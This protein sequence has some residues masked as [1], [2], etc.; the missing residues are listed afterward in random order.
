MKQHTI[1]T[2]IL[3]DQYFDENK[4]ITNGFFFNINNPLVV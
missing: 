3:H 2:Y 1:K 4:N